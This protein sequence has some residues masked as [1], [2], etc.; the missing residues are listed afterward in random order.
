MRKL[1]TTIGLVFFVFIS[2]SCE[3]EEPFACEKNAIVNRSEKECAFARIERTSGQDP[4]ITSFEMG[5][6]WS[7]GGL[8]ISV[9]SDVPLEEK[10]Y[11]REEGAGFWFNQLN[12]LDALSITITQID[13]EN[14]T[15]SGSFSVEAEGNSNSQAYTYTASGTFT[16]V[17]Y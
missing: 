15:I 13:K 6:G 1:K 11:T 7:T 5:I 16:E 14:Q 9:T 2:L 17:F 8:E 10:T 3:K 12:R 4:N